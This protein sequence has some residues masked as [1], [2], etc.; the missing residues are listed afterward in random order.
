MSRRLRRIWTKAVR[1][2]IFCAHVV[3]NKS[4]RKSDGA[5]NDLAGGDLAGTP[6][7]GCSRVVMDTVP[8]AKI[9]R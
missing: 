2:Q 1:T 7:A 9:E 8:D 4:R 5:S 6:L 3:E